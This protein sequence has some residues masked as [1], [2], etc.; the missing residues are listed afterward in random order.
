MR[1]I[2]QTQIKKKFRSAAVQKKIKSDTDGV[3]GNVYVFLSFAEDLN[4]NT[5]YIGEYGHDLILEEFMDDIVL[6][7]VTAADDCMRFTNSDGSTQCFI[8][9]DDVAHMI[10]KMKVVVDCI[11]I[12]CDGKK[13]ELSK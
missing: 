4:F 7:L 12:Y 2:D 8:A 1:E 5:V 6:V 9:P 10:S 3:S 11:A 13:K